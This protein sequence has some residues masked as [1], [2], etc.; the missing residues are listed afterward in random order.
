MKYL[1]QELKKTLS[2]LLTI[3]F[4]AQMFVGVM[5][6]SAS[7]DDVILPTVTN[8]P[9]IGYHEGSFFPEF[10][11]GYSTYDLQM[12]DYYGDSFVV[13]LDDFNCDE[14]HKVNKITSIQ[15][16]GLKRVSHYDY[17]TGKNYYTYEDGDFPCYNLETYEGYTSYN[18][19]GYVYVEEFNMFIFRYGFTYT[20]PLVIT[21]SYSDGSSFDV[22]LNF[23]KV[24]Y[25]S[26]NGLSTWSYYNTSDN[27]TTYSRGVSDTLSMELTTL[28]SANLYDEKA[29][30]KLENALYMIKNTGTSDINRAYVNLKSNSDVVLPMENM[31]ENVQ[32]VQTRVG[33]N[34][35][36]DTKYSVDFGENAVP[37]VSTG[38]DVGRAFTTPDGTVCSEDDLSYVFYYLYQ[39]GYRYFLDSQGNLQSFTRYFGDNYTDKGY[40]SSIYKGDSSKGGEVYED[41]I[42]N[43]YVLKDFYFDYWNDIIDKNR[44]DDLLSNY[45]SYTKYCVEFNTDDENKSDEELHEETIDFLEALNNYFVSNSSSNFKMNFQYFIQY[46]EYEYTCGSNKC[47]GTLGRS[48]SP[49]VLINK[50]NEENDKSKNKHITKIYGYRNYYGLTD[51]FESFLQEYD[52]NLTVTTVTSSYIDAYRNAERLPVSEVMNE[53]GITETNAERKA[54]LSNAFDYYDNN[55]DNHEINEEVTARHGKMVELTVSTNDLPERNVVNG[56][57]ENDQ[58]RFKATDL[59]NIQKGTVYNV[60]NQVQV[61]G[62]DNFLA[63]MGSQLGR[64]IETEDG[65]RW[66]NSG[67]VYYIGG[68]YIRNATTYTYSAW[69][70]NESTHTD[71]FSPQKTSVLRN[72]EYR[73]GE[74]VFSSVPDAPTLENFDSENYSFTWTAPADEGLGVDEKGKAIT[75]ENVS[76]G[77]YKI[78]LCN[79]NN[80]ILYSRLINR[81]GDKQSYTI[82]EEIIQTDVHYFLKITAIS[83]IGESEPAVYDFCDASEV[84]IVMTADQPTYNKTD[85]VAFTETVTNIGRVQLTNV[86][87]NQSLFG[88]YDAGD[89]EV[90]IMG[91][92][93]I[94]PKLDVDESFTFTYNVPASLAVDNKLTNSADVSADQKATDEFDFTVYIL[95]P[96]IGLAKTVSSNTFMIDDTITYTDTV[97]NTSPA[98]LKNIVVT[99]DNENGTFVGIDEEAVQTTENPNVVIIKELKPGESYTL[100]YTLAAKDVQTD[101]KHYAEGYTSA[102]AED[103]SKAETSV[104]YKV[105]TPEIRLSAQ[106][107]KIVYGASE[108]IVYTYIVE[109]SGDCALTDVKLT[110]SISGGTFTENKYGSVNSDGDFIIPELKVRERAVITYTISANDAAKNRNKV[111]NTIEVSAAENTED[112]AEL[113]VQVSHYGIKVENSV[114]S[115]VYSAGDEIKFT[116]TVTNTGDWELTNIKV[117]ENI[118]GTFILNDGAAILDGNVVI[119]SLQPGESYEYS[120][121][122]T[123]DKNTIVDNAVENTVTVTVTAKEDVS[124]SDTKSVA[125]E[126]YVED[127]D[128]NTDID[129]ET[130]T[131]TDTSVTTDSETTTD[132]TGKTDSETT[133]TDTT[134]KTD[135]ETTTDTTG[136]TDSETTTDTTGKTDSET[137]TTD[138]TGK[139][140]SET[141]T[142]DTTGKTDSETTTD[143]TGKTDSETTTDTTGKTDSETTT[144]TTGKT[145]SETETDTTGKTD[146]ET[147]TD[148]TDTESP[149]Q[150]GTSDTDSKDTP[151]PVKD[152]IL[153]DINGDGKVTA[154]DSMR[155]Q[156]AVIN[157]LKLTDEQKL[158]ADVNGDGKVTAK[159][160]LEIL[161]YTIRM[162]KNDKIGQKVS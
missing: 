28:A 61:T 12:N 152:N 5:G 103:G 121:I 85:T 139:T 37:S 20:N 117:E 88:K 17:Q 111:V 162:S 105:F 95:N 148:T 106:T 101:K 33:D 98:T 52:S 29:F 90:K 129:T 9:A 150:P 27:S 157:L 26:I 72:T 21:M 119:S 51:E 86:T 118:P 7:A 64:Y 153:G 22:A 8:T 25:Y 30:A 125:V 67:N 46:V 24:R 122:V 104:K 151:D 79:E 141:T 62:F 115:R 32:L 146:S 38:I 96:D 23:K 16:H 156:R 78:E 75:D 135:S 49:E 155:V 124:D 110:H 65:L 137:T 128:E 4:F 53:L 159:D 147:E 112:S 3:M 134:G 130:N 68:D 81:K 140:D 57:Y 40:N 123:A 145:D 71:G 73:W 133:T 158:L 144:D 154:A 83:K 160:A 39:N 74:I 138:T 114:E 99:E 91:T 107:E 93:M 11:N 47:V 109:N 1:K 87:V 59:K 19:V 69:G 136:K 10:D 100:T 149:D 82:P 50:I 60:V 13:K 58:I 41:L 45:G 76:V 161:R 116:K 70:Y 2:T 66:V 108:D 6:I 56:T 34:I 102:E 80:G 14:D 132:T 42:D 44:I 84:E 120:Y 143:T 89:T 113:S 54:V 94:I 55:G 35:V 48:A 31:S 97:T 43:G 15:A 63:K 126:N 142:T 127:T 92:K 131:D 18:S 36:Y 77:S